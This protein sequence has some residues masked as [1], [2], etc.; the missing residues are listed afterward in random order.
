MNEPEFLTQM[1]MPGKA[2]TSCVVGETPPKITLRLCLILNK[3]GFLGRTENVDRA[4][5]RK[6]EPSY[7]ASEV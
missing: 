3:N 5:V 1:Q 7:S 6:E 4:V 2:V